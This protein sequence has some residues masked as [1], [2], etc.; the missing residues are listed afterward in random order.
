MSPCRL[1]TKGN[2]KD[3]ILAPGNKCGLPWAWAPSDD[4]LFL[5]TSECG[6]VYKVNQA[7][8]LLVPSKNKTRTNPPDNNNN[9]K[10]KKQNE[11]KPPREGS[12]AAGLAWTQP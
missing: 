4:S 3:H 6:L 11:T 10:T 5:D 8:L 1:G 12:M 9:S 7:V 2:S